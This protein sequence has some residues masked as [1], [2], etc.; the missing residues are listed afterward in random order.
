LVDRARET[1]T[2]IIEPFEIEADGV[3]D[4]LVE[5][6]PAG[7]IFDAA[8]VS[9]TAPQGL[10]AGLYGRILDRAAAPLVLLDTCKE[11]DA[12]LL[13]KAS[14]VKVNRKEYGLLAPLATAVRRIIGVGNNP[15]Y[16]APARALV[17][18]RVQGLAA[19]IVIGRRARVPFND[20][21]FGRRT[22]AAMQ[23]RQQRD[24][25]RACC[26]SKSV[27]HVPVR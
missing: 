21:A 10:P 25:R 2:E 8:L 1:A 16:P 9:G 15:E 3:S 24:E 11:V 6:V 18:V 14:W 26:N 22:A 5:M 12:S 27:Q 23:C 17:E 20:R 19:D 4:A 13:A 7:G